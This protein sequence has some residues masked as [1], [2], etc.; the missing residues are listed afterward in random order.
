MKHLHFYDY[1]EFAAEVADKYEALTDMYGEISVIAKYNEMKSIIAELVL[2]DYPIVS[3]DLHSPSFC[4]YCD[5]YILS[6]N[7]DGIWCQPMKYEH[8]QYLKDESNIT[9][10]LDNCSSKVIPHCKADFIYEI[11]VGEEEFDDLEGSNTDDDSGKS[12]AKSYIDVEQ[13]DKETYDKIIS[14]FD[15][16]YFADLRKVLLNY[17]EF[18]NEINE[19]QKLFRL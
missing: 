17:C 18:M 8:D 12:N 2:C 10:V 16:A 5:A 1:K 14:S 11:S 13:I 4:D 9:Y 3:I 6:L 19:W 15:D 7:V